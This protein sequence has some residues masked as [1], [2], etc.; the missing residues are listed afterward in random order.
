MR[1]ISTAS[2][3]KLSEKTGTEPVVIVEV[4]WESGQVPAAYA[5]KRDS[6]LDSR[7]ISVANLED[8]INVSRSGTSQSVTIVFDDTDRHL[9][10]IFNN[11]DIHKKRVFIYQWFTGIPLTEKFLLFSGLIMSPIVWKE[12]DRTLTITVSS[13]IDD[14]E[15]GFSPEEGEFPNLPQNMVGTVWPLVFGTVAK[16]PLT[17]I[18]DIPYGGGGNKTGSAADSITKDG[19]GIEDPALDPAITDNENN[20]SYAASLAQVMFIGYLQASHTARERGELGD[21]DDIELGKGRFSQLAKQYLAQGNQYLLQ[22]QKVRR[23]ND[24]LKLVRNEQRANQKDAVGVTNGSSF[25]QGKEVNVNLGGAKHTGYFLG[26]EF[27]ITG[28]EHPDAELFQG[29]VVPDPADDD[30]NN[31]T[32]TRGKFFYADSGVPL[33]LGVL[34]SSITAEDPTTHVNP[35]RYIVASTIQVSVVA[36]YAYRT[37]SDVRN[38]YPVPASYYVVQQL[39][40]GTLPVT[41]VYLQQPLSSRIYS[42]GKSEGW[43]DELYATVTSPIGPNTV[44]II[45]WLIETYTSHE[46]DDDSFAEVRAIVD[47]YPSHFAVIDRPQAIALVSQIARQARCIVW[48]KNNKFFIKYLPKRAISVAE[49]TEAD[50]IEQTLEVTLTESED[51][52]TKI[53]ASWRADH[54]SKPN[55]VV[56]RYNIKYYGMHERRDSYFIYNMQQ[57]VEKSATFW[58]IREANTF[59]KV[60][61][62]VP[63]K[64]L[65]IEALDTVTLNFSHDYVANGPIDCIV[66]GASIDTGDY[67]IA[68]MLWVP[69]RAGEML[70][71]DFAWTGDLTVQYVFPTPDDVNKGRAGSGDDVPFNEA[72]TLPDPSQDPNPK[73]TQ[74]FSGDG[75]NGGSLHVTHRR[76]TWGADPKYVVDN[77]TANQT[78]PTIVTRVDTVGVNPL[79]RKPAGTTRYQINRPKVKK[80]PIVFELLP[81]SFVAKVKSGTGDT[82][83]CVVYPQ[84]LSKPSRDITNVKVLQ[85]DPTETIPV[86]TWVFVHTAVYK[87]IKGNFIE[88]W[89]M[90]PPVWL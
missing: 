11:V 58:L 56:L 35:V 88:E 31:A 34:P 10:N 8:V 21:L 65:N 39:M 26:D 42:D 77:T 19:T 20:A 62:K 48:M 67:T 2:L 80:T 82:Y 17:S 73:A 75:G 55:L 63:I 76:H 52:N 18:D 64:H 13:Q 85:I 28:R 66:E 37:V 49:I 84:G 72:V 46:V 86:D 3:A 74:P 59:K 53:V 40:Y 27:H 24:S 30:L 36:L 70:E 23:N 45:Q 68:L 29:L 22:S 5:D 4:E 16:L 61:L 25:E 83:T 54:I 57:L 69:V 9:K 15:V 41:Q 43:D 60:T 89:Y 51:L 47:T 12:G 38:L 90:Q 81:G 50:I 7:I 33:A 44:D 14:I 32:F 87:D 71:Y 6:G 1:T 78:A 79:G